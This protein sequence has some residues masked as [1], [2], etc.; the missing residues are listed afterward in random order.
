MNPIS[1]ILGPARNVV[2]AAAATIVDDVDR[3]GLRRPR[4]QRR[5]CRCND[6]V[7]Y[8]VNSPRHVQALAYFSTL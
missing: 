2:D 6:A 1:A 8:R 3:L 7:S 5:K 4:V